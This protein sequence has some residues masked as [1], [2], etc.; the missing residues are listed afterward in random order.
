MVMAFKDEVSGQ[1]GGPL[2]RLSGT[3]GKTIFKSE[4]LD[5]NQ[6]ATKFS[7]PDPDLSRLKK[8]LRDIRLT[9]GQT[10]G[11]IEL[12]EAAE[13]VFPDVDRAAKE[14]LDGDRKGKETGTREKF[15]NAG[16]WVQ[17]YLDR[18]GQAA[19]VRDAPFNN[20][21]CLSFT[22]TTTGSRK[23]WLLSGCGLVSARTI[24]IAL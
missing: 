8:G 20:P 3:L 16:A 7:N 6:T 11:E 21:R 19:Y 14:A 22:H 1:Q 4:K 10:R 9:S 23:S 17:D 13:L 24:Y 18:K 5:I 12:P 15:K 2:S